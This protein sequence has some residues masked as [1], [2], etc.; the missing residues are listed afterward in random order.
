MDRETAKDVATI[1]L[2]VGMLATWFGLWFAAV[3]ELAR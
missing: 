1:L 2:C 3:V